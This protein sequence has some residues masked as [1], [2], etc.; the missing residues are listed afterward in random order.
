MPEV[1]LEILAEPGAERKPPVR[2]SGETFV[3]GRSQ[4]CSLSVSSDVASREHAEL[5]LED[6]KWILA[7]L[8]SSNGTWLNERRVDKV[9][10]CPH[11]VITLGKSGVRVRILTLDPEPPPRSEET[12]RHVLAASRPAAPAPAYS[13]SPPPAPAQFAPPAPPVPAKKGGLSKWTMFLFLLGAAF[14]VFTAEGLWK[15][16]WLQSTVRKGVTAVGLVKEPEAA[17]WRLA[18]PY[19]EVLAPGYWINQWGAK[20]TPGLWDK[21]AQ[22]AMD[23]FCALYFGLFGI[24]LAH[25]IRRWFW[26]LVF[27]GIHLAA[28]LT[29]PKA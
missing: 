6:G 8:G 17:T 21:N 5:R 15:K 28:F 14:G 16:D 19:R 29:L 2:L 3:L 23:V 7:D 18:F 4:K 10:V 26:L 12:T 22:I 11:D 13:L 24:V 20:Y 1:C 25:P 9:E 27:A